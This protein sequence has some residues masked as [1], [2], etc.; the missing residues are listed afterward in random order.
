MTCRTKATMSPRAKHSISYYRNHNL[1]EV[2]SISVCDVQALY[3][4]SKLGVFYIHLPVHN[5][6]SSDRVRESICTKCLYSICE[7]VEI[8]L[9][10][11]KTL[12]INN[13]VN[14]IEYG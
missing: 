12:E 14:T 4:A 11:N 13:D 5:Q 3:L 7:H 6:F 10:L 9:C 1:Q 8:L 2:E